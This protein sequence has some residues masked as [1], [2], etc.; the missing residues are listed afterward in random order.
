MNT[1]LILSNTYLSLPCFV[2]WDNG[3]K[4]SR[5]VKETKQIYDDANGR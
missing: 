1:Y 5:L 4:V 3:E 2:Q